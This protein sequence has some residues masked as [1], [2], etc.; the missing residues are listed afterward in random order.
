MTGSRHSSFFDAERKS[1]SL[2]GVSDALDLAAGEFLR[3]RVFIDRSLVE[4]FANRR[5]CLSAWSYPRQAGRRI[6]ECCRLSGGVR[7]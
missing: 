1:I 4:V 7:W 3:L 5:V 2:K 6:C